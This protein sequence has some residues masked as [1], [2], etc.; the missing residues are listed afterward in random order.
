MTN[1]HTRSKNRRMGGPD[2]RKLLVGLT[3]S[4]EKF[5]GKILR[6]TATAIFLSE[7]EFK[8][9]ILCM[10]FFSVEKTIKIIRMTVIKLLNAIPMSSQIPNSL[11]WCTKDKMS[12]CNALLDENL[13]H[14]LSS[15]LENG[16]YESKLNLPH[17][18]RA[19]NN[20]RS[21]TYILAGCENFACNRF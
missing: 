16:F 17:V 6:K 14:I 15:P 10:S 12:F 13:F 8:L 9:M 11:V 3:A 2:E 7:M 4:I 1:E 18:V 19:M 20:K 5:R 21:N